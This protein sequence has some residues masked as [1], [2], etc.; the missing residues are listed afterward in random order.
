M[1]NFDALC[2]Q[3]QAKLASNKDPSPVDAAARQ[4]AVA[5]ILR[6]H[7][8]AAELL[9]I[10]R[11]IR[12]NDH[13][14]G[15]LG[16]PGGRWQN[17]DVDLLATAMRETR[18]EVGLDLAAGGQVLGQLRT[19]RP[20]NPLIPQIDVTPFLFTA[21]AKFHVLRQ[22][23]AGEPLTLNHEVAAAFWVP[24]EHLQREGLSD[25]VRFIHEGEERSW[26]AYPS[27]YG[28]IWGLTERMLTN[29]LELLE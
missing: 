11:A 15:H 24:V 3:V 2:E 29:F 5:L 8:E 14:S 26:P 21:P 17:D 10:K 20:R 7:V 25:A 27:E 6:R 12:A 22:D 16:L 4:A 19:L 28:P 1:D 9:I 23:E 13:W 18:E